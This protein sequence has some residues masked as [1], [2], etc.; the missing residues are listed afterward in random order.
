MTD[1]KRE[2]A[3]RLMTDD[4]DAVHQKRSDVGRHA[5]NQLSVAIAASVVTPWPLVRSGSAITASRATSMRI[6]A[7][8]R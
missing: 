1:D 4:T 3:C 2:R 7:D 8:L 6:A 5:F